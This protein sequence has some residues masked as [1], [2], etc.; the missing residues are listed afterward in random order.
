M[1][2]TA[3]LSSRLQFAFASQRQ[4]GARPC[5]PLAKMLASDA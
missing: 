3:L 1:E 4:F 5:A 2:W